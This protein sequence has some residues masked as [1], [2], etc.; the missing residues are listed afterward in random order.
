MNFRPDRRRWLATAAGMALALP[1]LPV[2]DAR[3]AEFGAQKIGES[4]DANGATLHLRLPSNRVE[5]LRSLLGDLSRG[6]ARLRITD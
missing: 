6:R 2:L 5:A 4:F 1:A 3:L